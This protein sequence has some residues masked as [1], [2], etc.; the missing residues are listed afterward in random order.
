MQTLTRTHMVVINGYDCMKTMDGNM[1]WMKL[2]R[3]LSK[4]TLNLKAPFVHLP[5]LDE[6]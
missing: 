6:F 1:K 5:L 2:T 3:S 4:K